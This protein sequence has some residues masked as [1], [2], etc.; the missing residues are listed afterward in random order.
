MN[1]SAT[2]KVE[3]LAALGSVG[4]G[5]AG[6]LLLEPIILIGA[7]VAAVVAT[8]LQLKSAKA[9]RDEDNSVDRR[10]V[11]LTSVS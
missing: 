4:A 10:T 3:A 6:V 2:G 8:T 9:S 5:L 11:K 1:I 7:A